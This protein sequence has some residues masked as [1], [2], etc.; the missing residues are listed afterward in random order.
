MLLQLGNKPTL[1]VSSRN[2]AREIMKTH[3]VIFSNRPKLTSATKLF[4]NGRDVAFASYGEYWRK[5]KGICTMHLL[6]TKRVRSFRAIREEETALMLE[7]IT[8]SLPS[9]VNL[10]EIIRELANDVVCRAAYGRKY[11]ED[12]GSNFRVLMNKFDELM[13]AFA[14]G[15]LIPRLSWIDRLSGLQGKLGRLADELDAF[16]EGVIEDH[17]TSRNEKNDSVYE[18]EKPKDFVDVLLELQRNNT[19]DFPIDR[20]CIKALLLDMFVAGTDTT[21][22]IIEWAMSELLRHP[23]AMK[24]LREEVRTINQGVAGVNEPELEKMEYLV[25]VIKEAFRLHPPGPL[26]LFRESSQDVKI[27]GYDIDARTQVIV[28]AWA[29]QRDP[30]FWDEPHEFIP[31][32]FLNSTIDFK[33]QDYH[34]VPFGAGRRK[35]PGMGFATISVELALANL[36][37]AFDWAL[38]G[39][40][41]GE[42]LDMDENAGF[43]VYR[44]HPLLVEATPYLCKGTK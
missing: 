27:N 42:T 8:R 37:Y 34:F 20:E 3:D 19:I 28:N 26:L 40:A 14:V 32:R 2:A 4:Y 17:L 16:L 12:K 1:I 10:T 43:T 38:P 31:E 23:K 35:C 24:E 6:S 9:V 25:A 7:K 5:M 44:R 36:M 13:G 29:I 15:D 11:S 33:G 21:S 41:Q 22:T 30:S 18:R 39:G